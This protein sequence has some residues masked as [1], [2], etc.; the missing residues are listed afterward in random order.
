MTS[1]QRTLRS[2]LPDDLSFMN[3]TRP[4]S[5]DRK[6]VFEIAEIWRQCT[7]CDRHQVDKNVIDGESRQQESIHRCMCHCRQSYR[8]YLRSLQ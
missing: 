5:K 4:E 6:Y 8:M 1:T 2:E 7:C 3:I